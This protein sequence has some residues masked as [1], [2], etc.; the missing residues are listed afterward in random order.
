MKYWKGVAVFI[1]GLLVRFAIPT[2]VLFMGVRC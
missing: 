1:L 2:R